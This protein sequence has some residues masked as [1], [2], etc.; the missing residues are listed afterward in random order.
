[1]KPI[2]ALCLLAA[3]LLPA[4]MAAAEIE[5]YR[6]WTDA[7]GRPLRAALVGTDSQTI[8]L[9]KE[10]GQVINLPIKHLSEA[11]QRRLQQNR[12]TSSLPAVPPPPTAPR[13]GPWAA[14][15][16]F[17]IY[18]LAP[19]DAVPLAEIWTAQSSAL[20]IDATGDVNQALLRRFSASLRRQRLGQIELTWP[21]SIGGIPRKYKVGTS[22]ADVALTPWISTDGQKA[23]ILLMVEMPG[24]KK[25]PPFRVKT[26]CTFLRA[27]QQVLLLSSPPGS[28]HAVLATFLGAKRISEEESQKIV[29][30]AR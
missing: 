7:R 13:D 18:S 24:S 19:R 29:N 5:E 22:S 16:K 9:K 11:D 8:T 26:T 28:Q 1:M 4:S 15:V 3:L 30:S 20:P 6:T 10:S 14:T 21:S 2:F 25:E 12:Q 27:G 23:E 17:E